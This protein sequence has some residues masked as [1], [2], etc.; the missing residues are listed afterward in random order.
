MAKYGATPFYYITWRHFRYLHIC[1]F[2]K[3]APR[4]L[5]PFSD[6][7]Y[8]VHVLHIF[9]V[10][11]TFIPSLSLH[12][13]FCTM[14]TSKPPK[15]EDYILRWQTKLDENSICHYVSRTAPLFGC[16]ELIYFHIFQ[17]AFVLSPKNVRWIQ[18]NGNRSTENFTSSA[19]VATAAAPG[20]MFSFVYFFSVV[21]I[22]L[23]QRRWQPTDW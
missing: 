3:N 7:P 21:G 2:I 1:I 9:S 6:M 16:I 22:L 17:F 10:L 19:T 14:Y 11:C 8:D 4:W 15:Q 23:H 20:F 12:H 18:R 13:S 5:S